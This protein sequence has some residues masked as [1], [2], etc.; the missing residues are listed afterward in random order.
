[1]TDIARTEP[2]F[3]L[4]ELI[5]VIVLLSVLAVVAII[6]W[7]A[8]LNEEAAVNEFKRAAR[9][10]QHQAM[11]RRYS[12]AG[13]AWGILVSGNQYTIKRQDDSDTASDPGGS[14]YP[15]GL[16]D[17]LS[18]TANSVWFNG[19]GEPINTSTGLP[20]ATDTSFTINSSSNVT[21]FRETGYVE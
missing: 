6:K 9:F 1:M 3:S 14:G 2:G 17:S 12:A 18:I 15:K 7:P 10:A 16:P 8:G 5:M 20:L 4:I 11:T 19:L 21:V 13:S